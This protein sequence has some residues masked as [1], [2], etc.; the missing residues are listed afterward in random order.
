VAIAVRAE[1]GKL[2]LYPGEVLIGTSQQGLE[3]FPAFGLEGWG[4]LRRSDGER[5]EF[6]RQ[7]TIDNNPASATR[8]DGCDHSVDD[9]DPDPK[10][11]SVG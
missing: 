10:T 1:L 3:D 11:E 2:N 8:K 5:R 4:H 6:V 7:F 9:A